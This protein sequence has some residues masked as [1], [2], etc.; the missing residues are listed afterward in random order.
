LSSARQGSTL[1]AEMADTPLLG[2]QADTEAIGAVLDRAAAGDGGV[3]W[4][5]G[6]AGI[7]KTRLLAHAREHAAARF[8]VL[9]TTG[10]E[11]EVDL[12]WGGLVPLVEPLLAAV[13]AGTLPPPQ[14]R[15]LDTVLHRADAEEPLD[16]FAV[17]LAVRHLLLEVVDRRPVLLVV[18]DAQWLD[19]STRLVIDHVARRVDG[20]PAA[21]L[22]ASRPENQP[23][24]VT[25]TPL[26]PVAEEAA[27]DLLQHAGVESRAVRDR[28]VEELGGRP[29]LLLAAAARLR[30][31]TDG[32]TA[33]GPVALPPSLLAL[34]A[35][36]MA[37]LDDPTRRALLVAATVPGG[38]QDTVGRALVAEGLDLA[39]LDPA[40]AD[41]IV[42]FES[43]RVAFVH[44]TLRSAVYHG[45]SASDRRRAHRA[46]GP[47]ADRPETQA[48]HLALG[49]EGPD[50]ALRARVEEA[51]AALV[52]RGAPVEAARAHELAA[53]LAVEPQAGARQLRLAAELLVDTPE[54]D[55]A[56]DLLDRADLVD[57]DVLEQA[58]AE[59]VRLRLAA[60]QGDDEATLDRLQ[61]L[62]ASVAD[63]DP[64]LATGLLLEAL[65]SLIRQRRALDVVVVAQQAHEISARA[66]SRSIRLRAEIAVGG[67]LVAIGDPEGAPLLEQHVVLLEE[68]GPA[69]AGP[70][71]AEVAAPV[72]G[73]L[74]RTDDARALL[75]GLEVDL[76]HRAALPVLATVLAA[77][78]AIAHGPDLPGTIAAA[79]EAMAL[80]EELHHPGLV[81]MPA[82]SLAIAAAMRGDAERTDRGIGALV[83]S[84]GENDLVAA[85]IARGALALG[86]G[87]LD[88][89]LAT[90]E[91]LATTAGVGTGIIRWEPEWAEALVRSQRR[92]DARKVLEDLESAG[93]PG[94]AV[95]GVARIE[96]MLADDEDAAAERF[97][98]AVATM[99]LA[100]NDVGEGRAEL[101]WGERLRRARR[102]AAARPHLERAVALLTSSGAAIWAERATAELA[103]AGGVT[104]ASGPG[105]IDDLTPQ[106]LQVAR[107]AAS[108]AS[109][110][111]IGHELFV[112]PRT[113]EAHLTALFRKLGVR[114]R[115]ELAARA[116]EEERLR[117]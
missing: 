29:M 43:G 34:A 39:A 44:P 5:E 2:R 106:E 19:E 17:V 9:S 100:G 86:Q 68:E 108:G 84:G 38:D 116:V 55:A 97:D 87:R 70:F 74:H 92:D 62:A 14:Q 35:D 49:A 101:A 63:D 79:E 59:R 113:V 73:F 107:L 13:P 24:P 78:A 6:E 111:D 72:L 47:V 103:L 105:G 40:E 95:G 57:R 99:R 77:K 83:T 31:G 65:R 16:P 28:L 110:R 93:G 12:A 22:V 23:A 90:Y 26:G 66:E 81:A 42:V 89:A 85:E 10:Y 69:R 98:L 80:A 27:G 21:V 112:S 60:R 11:S 8:L 18:D 67:A 20:L 61:A 41:G 51:A 117:A 36:R 7:G 64:D 33:A 46:V 4:F 52:T 91:A 102:R 104:A 37:A 1:G 50:E 45:A 56:L 53:R 109:N 25:P 30:D 75:D 32:T 76:R 3:L 54:A 114:N 94:W 15:A 71:L 82:S 58:R 115:R 96:G 88:D 48:L